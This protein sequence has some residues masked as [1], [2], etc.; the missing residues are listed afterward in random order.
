MEQDVITWATNQGAAMVF[1]IAVYL[2]LRNMIE[3][4]QQMMKTLMDKVLELSNKRCG[5]EEK[6]EQG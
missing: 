5:E 2:L 3:Q 6:G 1:A 4:H